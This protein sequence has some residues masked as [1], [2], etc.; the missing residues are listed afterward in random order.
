MTIRTVS[1]ADEMRFPSSLEQRAD[2]VIDAVKPDQE[3]I[4]RRQGVQEYVRH[5]IARC[6]HPEQVRV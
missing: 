5:I 6:F 4:E 2:M 3:S 1:Q